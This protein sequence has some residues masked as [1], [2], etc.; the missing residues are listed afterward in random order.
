[1]SLPAQAGGRYTG[2]VEAVASSIAPET[3]RQSPLP[4]DN[5]PVT[6]LPR[7]PGF[8]KVPNP[9]GSELGPLYQSPEGKQWL[10]EHVY[11]QGLIVDWGSRDILD[12]DTGEIRGTVPTSVPR[13]T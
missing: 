7:D 13:M 8:E 5:V 11:N 3:A 9:D 10:D 6:P 12:P 2:P 4:Y 1:M